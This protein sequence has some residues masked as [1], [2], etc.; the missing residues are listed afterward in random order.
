MVALV[1]VEFESSPLV[2]FFSCESSRPGSST[3]L[4]PKRSKSVSVA[5]V[6]VVRRTARR[7]PRI[8]SRRFLAAE[9]CL[10]GC[11]AQALFLEVAALYVVDML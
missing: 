2:E 4:M 10:L 11:S 8:V 3:W 7:R 1:G 9:G 5:A 6:D